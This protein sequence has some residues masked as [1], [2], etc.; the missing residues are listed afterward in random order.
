[1][2]QFKNHA[3]WWIYASMALIC[4]K[5]CWF[6]PCILVDMPDLR[7]DINSPLQYV[8]IYYCLDALMT[9][10]KCPLLSFWRHH[11][12]YFLSLVSTQ[13]FNVSLL[14]AVPLNKSCTTCLCIETIP[15]FWTSVLHPYPSDEHIYIWIA[16]FSTFLVYQTWI[17]S[18][19]SV[20]NSV[21]SNASMHVFVYIFIVFIY[22]FM[23][24]ISSFIVLTIFAIVFL[25]FDS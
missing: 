1:M 14:P 19:I 24:F 5:N 12:H 13:C 18:L 15:A 23:I 11:R 10:S 4:T 9:S 8:V 17:A 6:W 21:S 2:N 7:F 22:I 20:T 25:C 16:T 3:I